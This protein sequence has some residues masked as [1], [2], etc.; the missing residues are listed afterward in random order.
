MPFFVCC[1]IQISKYSAVR[2]AC[3]SKTKTATGTG[4]VSSNSAPLRK[5]GE[6]RP[7]GL[8]SSRS[9]HL[10]QGH[11]RLKRTRHRKYRM[12]SDD[13]SSLATHGSPENVSNPRKRKKR[14]R[15]WTA[16]D[17]ARHRVFEKG[18]REAFNER[19]MVSMC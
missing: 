9:S 19:L 6:T 11:R 1:H 12:M 13:M 16:S 15:T 7:E 2:D 14:V 10:D 4:R 3:G 17:R 5:L 18:R 8:A